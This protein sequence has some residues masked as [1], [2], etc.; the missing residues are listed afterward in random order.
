MRSIRRWPRQR[1]STLLPFLLK[2][3]A[4]R[5]ELNQADGVHPN[6]AGERIVAEN[7]GSALEPVLDST[8]RALRRA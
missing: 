8:A 5:R 2:D 7:S 4:G 6:Y 1:A 3:V